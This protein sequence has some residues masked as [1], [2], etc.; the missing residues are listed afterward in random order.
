MDRKRAALAGSFA[1]YRD[2]SAMCFDEMSDDGQAKAQTGTARRR[3]ACLSE[4]IEYIRK[5]F[6]R[7]AGTGIGHAKTCLGFAAL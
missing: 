3:R 6:S 7:Y 5:K 2:S 1:G 4:S